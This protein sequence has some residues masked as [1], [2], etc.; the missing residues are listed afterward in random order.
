MIGCKDSKPTNIEEDIQASFDEARGMNKI[1]Y[2]DRGHILI[3]NLESGEVLVDMNSNKEITAASL[4][5][6]FIMYAYYISDVK[7]LGGKK[8]DIRKMIAHSSNAATNRVIEELGG[9][10]KTNA[11][12]QSEFPNTSLVEFIPKS[13]KTYKNKTTIHDLAKLFEMV[14][15]R[16][17]TGADGMYKH[18]DAYTTSRFK[19]TRKSQGCERNLDPCIENMAGKTGYVY[20]ANGECILIKFKNNGDKNYLWCGAFSNP[21]RHDEKKRSTR[22]KKNTDTV[23]QSAFKKTLTY[24]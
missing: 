3:K 15:H 6:P 16:S 19:A 7:G 13:G 9:L 12:I 20:G 5:K 22:W 17:F 23:L 8:G 10:H 4:I 1:N 21:A 11:F 18:F 24:F 14:Y 2:N